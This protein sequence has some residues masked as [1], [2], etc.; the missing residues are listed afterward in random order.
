PSYPYPLAL[1][2]ALPILYLLPLRAERER[3]DPARAVESQDAIQV[4]DL[5]LQQL[6]HRSLDLHGV[7]L[8]LRVGIAD[9][10]LVGPGDTNEQVGKREAIVPHQEVVPP[11]VRDLGIDHGPALLV[12]LDEHDPHRRADLRRR[13]CPSHLV[14]L[15]GDRERIPQIVRDEPRGGGL[16]VLDPLA[17][18]PQ[19]RIA[20]LANASYG[21]GPPIWGFGG[22]VQ[23]AITSLHGS[24][25]GGAGCRGLGANG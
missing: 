21:H 24:R 3:V 18:D 7:L 16:R 15:L 13:E 14:F 23:L 8:A 25:R 4:V 12:H 19:D 1:H 20:Q 17:A 11:Y 2:D 10:D 5:V 9:R 6:R 22:G